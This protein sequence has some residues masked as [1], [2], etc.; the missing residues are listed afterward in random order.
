MTSLVRGLDAVL[1]LHD[2]AGRLLVAAV[3]DTCVN[4]DDSADLAILGIREQPMTPAGLQVLF[5]NAEE[6]T[7]R[8]PRGFLDITL[9]SERSH[10]EPALRERGYERAY[11][12]YLMERPGDVLLP[13]LSG[14]L[15]EGWHWM[16]AEDDQLADYHRVV[17]E[18]FSK[19]PG[20]FVPPLE[21][22]VGA[23]RRGGR[24]PRVLSEGRRVRGFA[25]VR[26]H[27]RASGAVGE[28][29][30][31]GREPALRG[32]GLGEHALQQALTLLQQE[33]PIA[34]FELEVA[35]RN[36]AALKLYQRH[37]FRIVQTMPV[38]RR[39]L[40]RTG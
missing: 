13:R 37:G 33:A 9:T 26:V 2:E 10:W 11:S 16:D 8:G 12:Q 25:T 24:R 40:S 34:K 27:E 19:V 38:F 32:A 23:L 28:V 14:L 15:P 35:A 1:D 17:S 39:D 30:S 29:R 4:V 22:M 3:V 20:A 7:R 21:E 31:I 6:V 18:A 5:E 36:E